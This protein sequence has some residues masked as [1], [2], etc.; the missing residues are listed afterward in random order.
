MG[1]IVQITIIII[2]GDFTTDSLKSKFIRII[3]N[4]IEK[5]IQ[6]FKIE[7]LPIIP[8]IEQQKKVI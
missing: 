2:N 4:T 5:R 3:K 1:N 8:E 6:Y 7:N